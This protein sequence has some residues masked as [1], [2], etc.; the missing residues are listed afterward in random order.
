MVKPVETNKQLSFSYGKPISVLLKE[1][2]ERSR[3]PLVRQEVQNIEQALKSLAMAKQVGLIKS[4]A[5]RLA[6]EELLIK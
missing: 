1:I 4:S 3:S 6:I 2:R 5:A